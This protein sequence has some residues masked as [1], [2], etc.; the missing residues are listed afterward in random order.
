MRHVSKKFLDFQHKYFVDID[1]LIA[2][3]GFNFQNFYIKN[4]VINVFDLSQN[5]E[6]VEHI[7][8]FANILSK[9]DFPYIILSPNPK[10]IGSNIFYFPLFYLHGYHTWRIPELKNERKYT[11]SCL[12]RMPHTH[13]KYNYIKLLQKNISNAL[14]S[15]HNI[16]DADLQDQL[17][18]ES[19]LEQY[20]KI[21][22]SLPN[23]CIN[24]LDIMHP[25]YKNTYCNIVT[26]TVMHDEIFLSEKIWKPIASGQFFLVAGPKNIISYL[27]SIG[28][29]VYDDIIDHSYDKEDNW[30][31]RIDKMHSSLDQFLKLDIFTLWN[32]LYDRR[33]L[34]CKKFF[35]GEFKLHY[36][37]AINQFQYGLM[38]R[39]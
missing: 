32:K 28:V 26:E 38:P 17:L 11:I 21:K 29:D 16:D 5:Y 12:N 9:Q 39:Y 37:N 7:T 2:A 23:S 18:S 15:F 35:N 19:I 33:L 4:D 1:R 36:I 22:Y 10:V 31:S 3:N 14:L 25:A 24:D 20:N 6:T 30:I 13:R 27:K 34:N 8:L